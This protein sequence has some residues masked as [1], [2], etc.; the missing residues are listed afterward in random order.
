M[1]VH[2]TDQPR[3][4]ALSEEPSPVA[5]A[6]SGEAARISRIVAPAG[7]EGQQA[8][9]EQ[10]VVNME[11]DLYLSVEIDDE[12]DRLTISGPEFA[13]DTSTQATYCQS[14]TMT[15]LKLAVPLQCWFT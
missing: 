10:P 9:N 11:D 8:T 6:S 14:G 1:G 13:H 4:P 12:G 2:Q 5:N 7:A 15:K 3:A